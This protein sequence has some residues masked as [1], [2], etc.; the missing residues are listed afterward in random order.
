MFKFLNL[1][2]VNLLKY[3]T[4]ITTL[5]Y[6]IATNNANFVVEEQESVNIKVKNNCSNCG[7]FVDIYRLIVVLRTTLITTTRG[8][9]TW[10]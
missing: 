1:L 9:W 8:I 3:I 4:Y 2:G 6:V 10:A 7:K 5:S